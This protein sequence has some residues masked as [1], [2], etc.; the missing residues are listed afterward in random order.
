M[1]TCVSERSGS[2]SSAIRFIAHTPP[3]TS[4]ATTVS[5]ANRFVAHQRMSFSTMS[6]GRGQ[7][8]EVPSPLPVPPTLDERDKDRDQF[9]RFFSKRFQLLRRHELCAFDQLEPIQRLF[10]FHET[11][12]ELRDVLSLRSRAECLAKVRSWRRARSQNLLSKNVRGATRRKCRRQS[13]DPECV[14]ACAFTDV[15]LQL[16]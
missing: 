7:K 12:V 10:Q 11:A 14:F 8:A 13:N 15:H 1:M 9:I 2:A 5:V 6:E 3:N 4:A 16:C